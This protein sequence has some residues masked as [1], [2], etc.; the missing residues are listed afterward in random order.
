[1]GPARREFTI[2]HKQC[3]PKVAA[4]SHVG[5]SSATRATTCRGPCVRQKLRMSHLAAAPPS[6]QKREPPAAAT[7]PLVASGAESLP[8]MHVANGSYFVVSRR[9]TSR[10]RPTF[11][12]REGRT[13]RPPR[14]CSW[15]SATAPSVSRRALPRRPGTCRPRRA[16]TCASARAA[17]RHEPPSTITLPSGFRRGIT[18]IWLPRVTTR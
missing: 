16:R 17:G 1:M 14:A 4:R 6:I 11:H 3:W 5:R 8:F 18:T 13:P 10:A 7:L 2:M 9:G 15:C 12:Q